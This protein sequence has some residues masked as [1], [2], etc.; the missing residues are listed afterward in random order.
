MKVNINKANQ[1][2]YLKWINLCIDLGLDKLV[3]E[4]LNNGT[5]TNVRDNE[6]STPLIYASVN[7][8]SEFL[9]YF[10]KTK[11]NPN[12]LNRIFSGYDS[13]VRMLIQHEAKIN[14]KDKRGRTSLHYATEGGL[15]FF[16][17]LKI[18]HYWTFKIRFTCKSFNKPFISN[19]FRSRGSG[20]I[21]N[22][23]RCR[24]ADKN[25]RRNSDGFGGNKWSVIEIELNF[26]FIWIF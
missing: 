21:A 24:S 10:L 11:N 18:L 22:A 16:F 8:E 1:I 9:L 2:S 13:I 15:T 19:I 26:K 3:Q 20:E 6:G 7:G 23:T 5:D 4:L 17:S 14:I 12:N 25:S